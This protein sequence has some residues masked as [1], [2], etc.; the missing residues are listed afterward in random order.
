MPEQG[1]GCNTWKVRPLVPFQRLLQHYSSVKSEV[2][3]L[4]HALDVHGRLYAFCQVPRATY[5]QLRLFTALHSLHCVCYTPAFQTLRTRHTLRTLHTHKARVAHIHTIRD[6]IW[7]AVAPSAWGTHV[8]YLHV[9]S[10]A[11]IHCAQ[12]THDTTSVLYTHVRMH[13]RA[14]SPTDTY[15]HTRKFIHG[16]LPACMHA[17]R[18]THTQ[19]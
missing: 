17:S 1:M 16:C 8:A 9:Y 7:F 19:T 13:A 6:S 3:R 4:K 15:G 14:Q 2:G 18:H 12:L 10:G 5:V 11:Y